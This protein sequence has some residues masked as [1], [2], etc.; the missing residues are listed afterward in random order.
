MKKLINL[1]PTDGE[2]FYYTSIFSL[3]ESDAYFSSLVSEIAWKQEPIFVFGKPIMQ[4]RLTAWYGDQ[5]KEYSYSG[6]TM[7]PSLWTPTLLEIK[8][9][10]ESISGVQFNSALLNQY[11]DGNDSVGWHRDNEKELGENPAIASV[12]FGA[13][14]TFHFRHS[15]NKELKTSIELEHGSLLLMTGE[16]QHKWHHSILKTQK[17]VGPRINITFRVIMQTMQIRM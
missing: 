16:T 12:S 7:R 14:R 1:L 4:P 5:G 13:T 8:Q 11:R 10:I 6:I 17:F 15:K 2:V 3:V 9:R